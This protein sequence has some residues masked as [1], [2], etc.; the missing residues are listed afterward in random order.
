M[1]VPHD[2]WVTTTFVGGLR[3]SG[4]TAPLVIDG[5]M[6]GTWFEA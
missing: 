3:L 5:P 4:M 6:T 2:H 1:A